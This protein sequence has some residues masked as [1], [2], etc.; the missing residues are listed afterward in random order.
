MGPG[1]EGR[2]GRRWR[3]WG[4]GFLAS[5]LATPGSKWWQAWLSPPWPGDS[6]CDL[7]HKAADPGG[8]DSFLRAVFAQGLRFPGGLSV[9]VGARWS[10]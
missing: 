1:H 6:L 7:P 5:T 2:C 10:W 3:G 8:G 9:C 4:W